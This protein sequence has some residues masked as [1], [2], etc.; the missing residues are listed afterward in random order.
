MVIVVVLVPARIIVVQHVQE[1]VKEVAILLAKVRVKVIVH[2][3]VH[4]D[5]V[6]PVTKVVHMDVPGVALDVVMDVKTIVVA[7]VKEHVAVLLVSIYYG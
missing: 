6:I 4:Q 7:H 5:A 2:K 1:L 3:D